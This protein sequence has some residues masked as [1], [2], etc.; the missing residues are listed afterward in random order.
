MRQDRDL[1][2]C[3]ARIPRTDVLH[4]GL[5]G[6]RR[7]TVHL[8]QTD[9]QTT[10]LSS[11]REEYLGLRPGPASRRALRSSPGEGGRAQTPPQSFSSNCYKSLAILTSEKVV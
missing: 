8:K 10:T 11:T 9:K 3:A 1:A 4:E 6:P 7:T 2:A 5:P